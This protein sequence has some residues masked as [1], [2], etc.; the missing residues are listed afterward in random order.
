[1]LEEYVRRLG[2][3]IPPVDPEIART[4]IESI[5]RERPTATQL[6]ATSL[7][8][9]ICQGD[10]IGRVEFRWIRDDGTWGEDTGWG[11][12]LSNSCDA[13]HDD[14]IT[15]TFCF[16]YQEFATDS[17]VSRNR[18]FVSAVASNL[19]THMF[20]LPAAPGI[21]DMVCDLTNVWTA[22]RPFLEREIASGAIHRFAALSPF[23]YYLFLSKLSLHYLRPEVDV[24]RL[25]PAAPGRLARVREALRIL[26]G[27]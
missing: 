17:V 26:K 16:E 14:Y 10:I 1:V 5:R 2:Q 9:G 6:Y 27:P 20:F 3:L 23:G 25:M 21:G 8:A 19:V 24:E 13:E 7:P 18:D 11:I 22:S 4:V 15:L 12:V